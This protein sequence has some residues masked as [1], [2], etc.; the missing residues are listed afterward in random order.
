L[1]MGTPIN[2]FIFAKAYNI[3][4]FALKVLKIRHLRL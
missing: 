4:E 1:V 3:T 2:G